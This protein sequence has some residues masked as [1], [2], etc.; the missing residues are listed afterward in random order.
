MTVV[1]CIY[2]ILRVTLYLKG[3]HHIYEFETS[4]SSPMLILII[5]HPCC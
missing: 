1:F 5:N 3:Y 4:K 2:Y